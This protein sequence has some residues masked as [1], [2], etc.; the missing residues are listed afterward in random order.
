MDE[1]NTGASCGPIK[2][3]PVNSA[4]YDRVAEAANRFLQFSEGERQRFGE[5]L[6]RS[7]EAERSQTLG[8]MSEVRAVNFGLEG[9][10]SQEL[11]LDNIESAMDYKPWTASDIEYGNRVRE[12]LVMAA[13]AILR[14]VPRS[15]RRELALQHLIDARMDANCAISFGGMF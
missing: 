14:N 2:G 15:P 13:K 1:R 10:R 4:S 7:T 11:S 6:H 3:G 12:S 8:G 9:Y 5:I